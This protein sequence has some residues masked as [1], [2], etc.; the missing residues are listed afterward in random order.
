MKRGT[1]YSCHASSH[2]TG[3]VIIQC[4]YWMTTEKVFMETHSID[5]RTI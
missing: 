5:S 1:K 3:L 2:N 4:L